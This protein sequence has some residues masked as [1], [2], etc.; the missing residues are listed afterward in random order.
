MDANGS[1][2]SRLILMVLSNVRKPVWLPRVLPKS[3][4]LIMRRLLPQLLILPLFAV[5]LQSLLSASGDYIKW[6]SKTLSSMVILLRKSICNLL[7]GTPILHTRS[8]NFIV[9]SMGESPRAW[10]AK[11]SATIEKFPQALMILLS[12]SVTLSRV[13]FCFFCMSMI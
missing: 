2:R 7:Q 6:M 4:G 3:M 8:A 13:L 5:Y 12:S 11:F 1:I 10:F 9:L